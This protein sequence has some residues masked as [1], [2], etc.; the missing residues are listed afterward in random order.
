MN[1]KKKIFLINGLSYECALKDPNLSDLIEIFLKG[2][3]KLSA[4]IAVAVNNILV[5]RSKWKRKKISFD[6]KIEIVSPF[7]GG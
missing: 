1:E 7:Y 5:E 4:K 6:D 2:D 3:K